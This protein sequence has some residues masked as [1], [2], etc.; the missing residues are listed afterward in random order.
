MDDTKKRTV[1]GHIMR[2]V[3]ILGGILLL[4]VVTTISMQVCARY[5]FNYSF[6]WSEE[7]PM[8]LFAWITFLGAGVG[9][10]NNEHMGVDLFVVHLPKTAQKI[11]EIVCWFLELVF[12]I[13]VIWAGAQFSY[14]LRNVNFT[15]V[16]FP[17]G[18]FYFS[19][20]VGCT[21]MLISLVAK[22]I[23]AIISINDKEEKPQ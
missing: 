16:A 21:L 12:C 14:M 3:N 19:L 18:G 4:G 20:V 13:C 9:V 11:I 2:S 23:L 5:L 8:I 22:V 17:K 6:P 7:L 1:L 15:A 10:Y